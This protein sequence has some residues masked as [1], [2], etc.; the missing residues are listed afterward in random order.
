MR[1]L[2]PA[3]SARAFAFGLILGVALPMLGAGCGGGESG[4]G[5][6]NY[7]QTSEKPTGGVPAPK[8]TPAR[9]SPK[10]VNDL[11]PRERRELAKTKS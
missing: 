10:D 11:S 2:L 1:R 9:V 5:D 7:S 8:V 6:A 3:R 4:G